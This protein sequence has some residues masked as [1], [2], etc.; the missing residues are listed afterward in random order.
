M[1]AII[2]SN[3]FVQFLPEGTPFNLDGVQY[4]Q[5]WLNLSTPQ[6]KGRLGI[7]DVVYGQRADD[8]YYWVS[9]DAPV[10]DGGVVKVN[11]TNT[12]K[13]LFE[14]QNQA[15]SAINA[16]AYSIL[17]PSDWMV[18]KAMETG[19]AVEANWASWRQQ[20]RDQAAAQVSAI[21]ACADVAALAALPSVEWAHDPNW[22]APA[23]VQQVNPL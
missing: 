22:V 11:Y 14:C 1:F 9:E 8:R 21:T 13:D 16:A 2:K 3:Q 15:V 4:P 20:I 12:P 23:E 5:N 18:V 10:V 17:L 7:V 6:E 19:V